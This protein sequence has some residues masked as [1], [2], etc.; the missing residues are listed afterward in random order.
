MLRATLGNDPI[1]FVK[2]GIK[3]KH[4]TV[5]T[6]TAANEREETDH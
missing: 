3:V 1:K 6:M 4:Y 2:I 5:V